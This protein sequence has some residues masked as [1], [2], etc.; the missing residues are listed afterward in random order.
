MV[1]VEEVALRGLLLDQVSLQLFLDLQAVAV[2]DVL[3][4]LV[5]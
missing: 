4:Q 2:P 1:G 3:E 5:E